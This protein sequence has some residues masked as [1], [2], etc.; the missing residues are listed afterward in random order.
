MNYKLNINMRT[1]PSGAYA[2]I[3]KKGYH[4]TFY[5]LHHLVKSFDDNRVEQPLLPVKHS[6]I[7]AQLP[8]EVAAKIDKI[9]GVNP[10][11]TAI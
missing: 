10:P 2:V 5:D 1:M 4:Y 7:I 11:K 8:N 9:L 6:N 3:D